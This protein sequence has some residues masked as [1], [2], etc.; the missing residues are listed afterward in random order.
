[1]LLQCS[2]I[3]LV[4]LLPF[5]L[6]IVPRFFSPFCVFHSCSLPPSLPLL[7]VSFL[8]GAVSTSSLF[9]LV[10]PVLLLSSPFSSFSLLPCHTSFLG[11][12][13]LV[14]D[15][16]H[17]HDRLPKSSTSSLQCSKFTQKSYLKSGQVAPESYLSWLKVLALK[18]L[19]SEMT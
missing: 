14:V 13:I 11:S 10:F 4:C 1:M 18:L 9:L 2:L 6:Y 3:F 19:L 7:P 15:Y 5:C 12:S 16:H 8:Y 17:N